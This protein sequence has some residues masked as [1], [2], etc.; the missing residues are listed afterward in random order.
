VI[1]S[2]SPS[3]GRLSPFGDLSLTRWLTTSPV[4][5]PK[6]TGNCDF[7]VSCEGFFFVIPCRVEDSPYGLV[8]GGIL[9]PPEGH[10]PSR[11]LMTLPFF[12]GGGFF[13]GGFFPGR[14]LV[15]FPMIVVPIFLPFRWLGCLLRSI[16][17]RIG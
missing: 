11:L 15:C 1:S 2:F 16:S 3:V 14:G 9:L 8:S 10:W 12:Q 13:F 17:P 7:V 5:F 4:A 6:Q